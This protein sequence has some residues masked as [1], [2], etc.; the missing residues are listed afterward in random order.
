[1]KHSEPEYT[2]TGFSIRY[3][4]VFFSLLL[5]LYVGIYI[6]VY[7]YNMFYVVCYNALLSI[8]RHQPHL[9]SISPKKTHFVERCIWWIC[10]DFSA[11]F[12]N[13]NAYRSLG[14][15]STIGISENFCHDKVA[16]SL[17]LSKRADHLYCD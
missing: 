14:V 17:M 9:I 3:A 1:M 6:Y 8:S 13:E 11:N 4:C 15:R 10:I 2:P 7:K 16:I 12:Q 5:P